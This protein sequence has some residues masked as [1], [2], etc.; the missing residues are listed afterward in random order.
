ML[1][2][3]AILGSCPRTKASLL[4]GDRHWRDFVRDFGNGMP[5][6]PVDANLLLA[7]SLTFR[8]GRTFQNY[9]GYVRSA[10]LLHGFG[11]EVFGSAALRRAKVVCRITR[12]PLI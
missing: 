2:C 10:N 5:P 8:C 1:L 11:D 3:Q 6:Y 9:L 12:P 4:S 7:W